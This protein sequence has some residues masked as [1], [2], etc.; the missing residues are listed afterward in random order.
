MIIYA[1]EVKDKRD[2]INLDTSAK[3]YAYTKTKD[4]N[5]TYRISAVL[6]EKVEPEFLSQ[7][8]HLCQKRFP[9]FY[10][11]FE[12]GFFW[13]RYRK[14]SYNSKNIL[15]KDTEYCRPI[16]TETNKA[17]LFRILYS[18][19]RISLEIFHGVTDGHGAI[20]FFKTL[21]AAYFN[22]MGVPVLPANGVLD[23]S[24]KPSAEELEDSFI[25]NYNR[26]Y[27]FLN[28]R[29]SSA[30]Q[31]EAT[32]TDEKLHIMQGRISVSQIKS[33]THS[34]NVSVTEWLTAVYVYALYQNI[35][36]KSK[37]KPI[38][39]QVPINLRPYYSS[40]TLR[41]FSLYVNVGIDPKKCDYEFY[42][43]LMDITQ[44]IRE[45][46]DK[47]RLQKMLNG[48][49]RDGEMLI[50][51]YSPS[52]MKKPFIKAGFLLYGE[53]LYTS[54]MSNLGVVDVPEEMKKHIEY[55][56]SVIGATYLNNIWA[57]VV[58]FDDILTVTFSS[59]D[60][61]NKIAQTYFDFIRNHGISV[62]TDN[63][64]RIKHTPQDDCLSAV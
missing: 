2:I 45:G 9:S 57:T 37:S 4:R 39:V 43:I 27:G 56:D 50:S 55:F 21:L 40:K 61:N 59:R 26:K 30:Y 5:Q 34:L 12:N 48:N 46:E 8:I 44:Q 52:F 3:L 13:K 19:R 49:V 41:N 53:R 47:E 1:R 54:P 23:I 7:A 20:T 58:T 6:K 17:P 35:E 14:R 62:Y 63:A 24:D 28:R 33:I 32:L 22:L 18:D 64:D 29:E 60:K 10:V 25:K 36:N 31:Y 38:K 16:D 51:K 15:F 42:D 11:N